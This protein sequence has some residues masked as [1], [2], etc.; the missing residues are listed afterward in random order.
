MQFKYNRGGYTRGSG[1]YRGDC[2][3]RAI[4]IA[5]GLPYEEVYEELQRRMEE[6]R[7]RSRAKYWNEKKP[8]RNKPHF[9]TCIKVARR[10]LQDLGW[11]WVPTMG[12]G[13]GCTVHLKA[14]ELPSGTIIAQVSNH[15]VCVIDGVMNDTYDS[16]RDETRCVYGYFIKDPVR[17]ALDEMDRTKSTKPI[18]D[19][20]QDSIS[21]QICTSC[22]KTVDP[23]KLKGLD[24]KEYFISGFC[25]QCQDLTFVPPPEEPLIRETLE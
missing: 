20:N 15:V 16:S 22:R 5:T 12:I 14:D 7:L 21:K 24:R 19:L 17:K 6:T 13:R 8:H 23:N 18:K 2:V 9:G 3:P 11:T 1:K 4:T 25:K 10:Y